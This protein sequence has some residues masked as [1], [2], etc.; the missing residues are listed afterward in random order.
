MPYFD[1]SISSRDLHQKKL[2]LSSSESLCDDQLSHQESGR[3]RTRPSYYR[4]SKKLYKEGHLARN[5]D[6][7]SY[8]YC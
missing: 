7:G 2:V 3:Q 8:Q 4:G 6:E 1:V 5:R